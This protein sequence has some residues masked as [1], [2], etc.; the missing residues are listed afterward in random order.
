[1]AKSLPPCGMPCVRYRH[2]EMR[3][4]PANSDRILQILLSKD[5]YNPI[6]LEETIALGN[7]AL[8]QLEISDLKNGSPR[9]FT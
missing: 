6:L 4:K 5:G 2:L 7:K 9:H 1:M 3:K 8:D